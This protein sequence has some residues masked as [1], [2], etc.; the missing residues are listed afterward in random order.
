[1]TYCYVYRTTGLDEDT[2]RHDCIFELLAQRLASY[3][4]MTDG[5]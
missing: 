5:Y 1:M 4:I 3:Y 2:I